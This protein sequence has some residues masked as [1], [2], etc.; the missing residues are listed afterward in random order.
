[1]LR[2]EMKE[3]GAASQIKDDNP[4]SGV[5]FK[6][7]GP[8]PDKEPLSTVPP[9][10]LTAIASRTRTRTTASGTRISIAVDITP[11]PGMHVYAPGGKYRAVAVRLQPDPFIR[12]HDLVYPEAQTYFFEPLKEYALVYSGPFRLALDITVGDAAGQKTQ[13]RAPSRLTLEGTLEYQACDHEYCYLPASAPLQW[14][15]KIKRSPSIR[16]LC[17]LCRR[18]SNLE[19]PSV[20]PAA[21]VFS[22]TLSHNVLEQSRVRPEY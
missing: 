18:C 19:H 15:V 1:M 2:P 10:V 17:K 8:Y 16:S 6:I 20:P 13:A 22:K 5:P 21:T 14:T 7:N 9:N 3:P 4:E 11:K 12:I